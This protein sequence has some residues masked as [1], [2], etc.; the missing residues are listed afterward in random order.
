MNSSDFGFEI[1]KKPYTA[2]DLPVLNVIFRILLV[3]AMS[4]CS[5]N[6]IMTTLNIPFDIKSVLIAS[7]ITAV[8]CAV[9]YF[10]L[11]IA[12]VML[13]LSFWRIM[14]YILDNKESLK[15]GVLSIF[16]QG[17]EVVKNSLGLPYADGFEEVLGMDLS[18]E[19]KIITILMTIVITIVISFF[20]GRYMSAVFGTVVMILNICYCCFLENI[21]SYKSLY[22]IVICF[23][24]VLYMSISGNGKLKILNGFKLKK[25]KYRYVGF[26][27]I[28]ITEFIIAAFIIGFIG[29]YICALFFTIKDFDELKQLNMNNYV[30]YTIKD[31]MVLKYAEYKKFEVP[32]E[33]DYGQLGFYSHVNPVFK[34]VS[35]V[36]AVPVDNEK[37]Y[38]KDFTGGDYIY[39]GNRWI[40]SDGSITVPEENKPVIDEIIKNMNITA[41]TPNLDEEIKKYLAENYTYEF[42]NGVVPFGKDFV[43]Y[44]LEESKQGSFAHFTSAA[45]LIYRELG[46]SAR[47]VG[48]YALDNEQ[49]LAGKYIGN[50]EYK[51]DVNK[52]NMYTWVEVYDEEKGWRNV[53]VSPSP[54]FAELAEKYDKEEDES[55]SD[56]VETKTDILEE[57]F[58]PIENEY[59]NPLHLGKNI[60]KLLA[61]IIVLALIIVIS[62]FGGKKLAKYIL[63]YIK[64]SKGSDSVKAYMLMD[65][66]SK[67]L[68]LNNNDYTEIAQALS[69]K[70]A[71]KE[72]VEKLAEISNRLVFS[73]KFNKSDLS[74]LKSIISGIK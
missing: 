23:L 33:V 41:D 42:D 49:I 68:K 26:N 31:V 64:Y 24:I 39:R 55:V 25:N 58:K 13:F 48:G 61:G 60:I 50:G 40:T 37:Y 5:V 44:F 12:V 74:E 62:L 67:K 38:I 22:I 7:A 30:K 21:R 73:N 10:N 32:K 29:S 28:I 65:N 20:I 35:S 2:Y 11:I 57:Y 34:K 47:Y 17:Y 18:H 1:Y 36:K 19:I 69:E 70:G 54:S 14:G 51:V 53:D 16:N 72:E 59:Y 56:D 71:N 63:W 45:V 46:I 9:M 66:L 15:L 27:S 43:N 8:V 4:V 3:F 52:V 6:L